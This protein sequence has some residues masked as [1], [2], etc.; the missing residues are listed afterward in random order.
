VTDDQKDTRPWQERYP[1][2]ARQAGQAPKKSSLKFSQASSDGSCPR[3]KGTSF[4]AK[5]SKG[6]KVLLGTTVG[7]GALLA[8]KTRVKCTTCGTE[9]L[10]G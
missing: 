1:N 6:A 3:C 7:V 5:R 10:R 9:Y 2:L 8:P 4:K